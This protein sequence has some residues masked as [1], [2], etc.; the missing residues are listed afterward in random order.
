MAEDSAAGSP[1]VLAV[2]EFLQ[3]IPGDAPAGVDIRADST[4]SS[5]YY[6]IKDARAAARAAERAA[7]VDGADAAPADWSPVLEVGPKKVL[8]NMLDKKWRRNEKLFVDSSDVPLEHL[9]TVIDS[10]RFRARAS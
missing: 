4:P 6:K 1:P 5:I 9:L 3:P 7:I 2:E 8:H 10:L